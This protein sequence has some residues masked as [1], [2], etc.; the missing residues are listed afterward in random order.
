MVH[1]AAISAIIVDKG[2]TTLV[3]YHGFFP[4]GI[5]MRAN[6]ASIT[7]TCPSSTPIL[8]DKIEVKN[9]FLGNPISFNALAKPIP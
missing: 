8:K 7:A 4:N 5:I 9:L 6:T 2:Y 3:L 1:H